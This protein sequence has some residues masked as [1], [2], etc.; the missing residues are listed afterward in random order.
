MEAQAYWKCMTNLL[1]WGRRM[2]NNRLDQQLLLSSI[3]WEHK[4]CYCIYYLLEKKKMVICGENQ[5]HLQYFIEASSVDTSFI[6][7]RNKM[8]VSSIFKSKEISHRNIASIL[9]LSSLRYIYHVCAIKD[10]ILICIK[11]QHICLAI[12]FISHIK[13]DKYKFHNILFFTKHQSRVTF[14]LYLNPLVAKSSFLFCSLPWLYTVENNA[15]LILDL[16]YAW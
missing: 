15:I 3:L 10:L 1:C 6:F 8:K 5:W 9:L 13:I 14:L 2:V 12:S 11:R 4:F 7:K 16:L